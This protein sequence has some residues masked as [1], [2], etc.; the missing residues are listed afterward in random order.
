MSGK[1]SISLAG[2]IG[3]WV[4]AF[5]ALL[6]LIALVGPVMIWAAA[7]TERNK[8]LHDAGDTEQPFIGSGFHFVGFDVRLFRRIRAPILDRVPENPALVWD[9]ARFIETN[10]T[11]A[12]YYLELSKA[13]L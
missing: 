3:T 5:L 4:A 10:P 8:A 13:M 2:T 9:R 7:R 6:A 12:T 1:D 11:D